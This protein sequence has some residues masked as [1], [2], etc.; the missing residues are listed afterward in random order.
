MESGQR[1]GCFGW[2]VQLEINR[3][4][5]QSLLQVPGDID[6]HDAL[7]PPHQQKQLE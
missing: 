3:A 6:H 5:P 4:M 7:V 1:Y 2:A